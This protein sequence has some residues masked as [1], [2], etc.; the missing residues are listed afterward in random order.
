MKIGVCAANTC[1]EVVVECDYV[2]FC[3]LSSVVVR[4]N[5]LEVY[6]LVLHA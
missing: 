6:V 5:E 3:S 1:N 2:A 4:W